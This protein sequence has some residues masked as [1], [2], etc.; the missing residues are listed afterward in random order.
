MQDGIL[1][2]AVVV[3]VAE[4]FDGASEGEVVGGVVGGEAEGEPEVAGGVVGELGGG[5]EVGEFGGLRE[6]VPEP[7]VVD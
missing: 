2:V 1:G 5:E 6:C 7:A 4:D 3:V